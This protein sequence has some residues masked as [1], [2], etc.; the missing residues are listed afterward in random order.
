VGHLIDATDASQFDFGHPLL[1]A[2]PFLT[3]FTH[4][5]K[6]SLPNWCPNIA[7]IR[8]LNLFSDC[9][10]CLLCKATVGTISAVL[11]VDR[12]MKSWRAAAGLWSF[13]MLQNLSDSCFT[14]ATGNAV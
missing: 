8:H 9:V 10:P 3:C 14:E 2:H 5:W 7:V 4:V 1:L 13:P 6:Y 11:E 12:I